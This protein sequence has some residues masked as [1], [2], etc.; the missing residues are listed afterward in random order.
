LEKITD[1][2]HRSKGRDGQARALSPLKIL[3]SFS[4]GC[5]G[6]AG[7]AGEI[8]VVVARSTSRRGEGR[9]WLPTWH[10]VKTWN[11]GDGGQRCSG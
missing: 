10:P 6:F 4:T 9:D 7:P 11:F 8:G 1:P 5:L 3:L 2:L